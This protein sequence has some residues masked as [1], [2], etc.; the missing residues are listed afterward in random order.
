MASLLHPSV[1]LDSSSKVV[2]LQ[3]SHD[4]ITPLENTAIKPTDRSK[5]TQ[6]EDD[7]VF[8][9]WEDLWVTVGSGK[10]KKP[11][12]QNLTGYAKPGQ[13]LAIMGPSGCGKTTLLDA[14]AGRLGSSKQQTGKILING[15]RQ[16]LAYGTSA[17]VTQ[18][19]AMLSTLTAGEALY[20]SC[21]LQ[22][23]DSMSM[24]E[25]KER[26]DSTLR[27]MGLQDAISTRIGGWT[28]KGLSSG[29][30]RRLSICIE[31]ITR[32]KLLFLDEPT[33]GLDSAAS[34][35][36]M[37]RIASLNIRDGIQR[38]IVAS[39]HQPS[40]EV[41]Q[42]FHNL[43]LLSSGET[44]YFGPA[45]EAN[46]FFATNGFPCPS[47]YNP[48]DHFLKII[49]KD[50]EQDPEEGFGTRET[51]EEAINILVESYKSFEI[52]KQILKE[53]EEISESD[54]DA[55]AKKRINAA[56]LT[57]CLVLI[58]RSSLHMYRD[59]SNYWLRLAVYVAIAISLGTMFYNVG[60][61]IESIQARGSLLTFFVS[62]LTF[63][64]LIGGFPPFLEEMKVFKRERLNGHYGVTA[65]LI[66]NTL[67]SI[68]Y[69]LLISLIPGGIV[70]FLSGL[71]KGLEHFLYLTSVLFATVMS[72]ESLMMVV[73]SFF[74]NFI[75]GM[76]IVGGIQGV[77][78]LLGGFYRLPDDLPKPFWRYPLY[79]VSFHKYAFQGLFKNEFEGLTFATAHDG[80]RKTTSGREILT[81]TW[82]VE[83]GYSKWVDLAILLG[84]IFLYRL[85]FLA[86][87]KTKENAKPIVAGIGCA[88]SKITMTRRN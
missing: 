56:F 14:L 51:T 52:R 33:S 65:F 32:P 55:I 69:M 35:Y 13:L 19:D 53:V 12:L 57:Q 15:H 5:G 78:I 9:T 63:I 67:S 37:S 75:M 60:S 1:A 71:H 59:M 50:F 8:I 70:Y 39:I 40:S 86:I 36:V 42:L 41:F 85:L 76:I 6:K 31:I 88:P 74:P 79:Y 66:G 30:K 11:L 82:Q 18:D 26:A 25:K 17:Y 45:S 80:D 20:Y 62:V 84:M 4:F 34:Y 16:A 21:Q 64:T 87:T 23:P 54:S 58:R 24:E 22:L 7:G 44:V 72:V 68:P 10:N 48:S 29:Q 61:S 47:L 2:E 83:M 3:T 73:G 49:N 27:E 81:N 46:E 28:S 77:M 38:T 43:C